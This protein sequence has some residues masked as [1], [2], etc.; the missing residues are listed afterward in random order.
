MTFSFSAQKRGKEDVV[1]LR[2]ERKLPGVLYGPE[3]KPVSVMADYRIF[4]KLHSEAGEASLIDLAVD[5]GKPIKVLIQDVQYDPVKRVMIHFD[6]RQINMD[7]EMEVTVE[8]N[9]VNESPAVKELGGTLI[10]PVEGL[11]VKCLPKDLVSEIIVDLSVLKTFDNII[12]LKDLAVPSGLKL[13]DNPEMAIAKVQAP[14]TEEQL[15]AME[16]EG[17]KGVEVVEQVEKKVKEGEEG[18]EAGAAAV[19]GAKTEAKP[20]EKK[21]EKKKE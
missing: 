20:E 15:K 21:E 2:A 19:E 17:K 9:F 10:K 7:K 3:I 1:A 4:E 6:L 12:R 5:S 8:L 16:E 14:L 13:M 11:K 18:E